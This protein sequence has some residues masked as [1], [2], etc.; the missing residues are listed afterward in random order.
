MWWG[1]G[2]LD[3]SLLEP[4]KTGSGKH[5]VFVPPKSLRGL[6]PSHARQVACPP[7]ARLSAMAY[8]AYALIRPWL[9]PFLLR[10]TEFESELKL[11]VRS[12]I[13]EVL[14]LFM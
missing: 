5:F 3:D 7:R 6:P 10:H 11:A 13:T 12:S 4:M 8:F 14:A 1:V 9:L 2:E